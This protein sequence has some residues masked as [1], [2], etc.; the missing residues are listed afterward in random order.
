MDASLA[1]GHARSTMRAAHA[2][3]ARVRKYLRE[4]EPMRSINPKA[5]TRKILRFARR[6]AIPG[7]IVRS[8]IADC[9]SWLELTPSDRPEW[10]GL[11]MY[12]TRID[13]RDNAIDRVQR[14]DPALFDQ[15]LL[16]RTAQR[17]D[18]TDLQA[19]CMRSALAL[20]GIAEVIAILGKVQQIA[21]PFEQGLILGARL[22]DQD[23]AIRWATF[24][25]GSHLS[26]PKKRIN[27]HLVV[28][29]PQI[30]TNRIDPDLRSAAA[31]DRVIEE[32]QAL[33]R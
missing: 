21:L 18:E 29:L 16:A 33:S 23:G 8:H 10:V 11:S 26:R 2:N 6:V 30:A 24:I 20:G 32:A 4:L 7:S 31:V 5:R 28:N 17:A 22:K 12:R 9:F 1:K 27:D 14:Y 13:L 19:F 25:P 15:H 3:D